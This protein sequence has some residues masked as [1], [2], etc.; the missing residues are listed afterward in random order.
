MIVEIYPRLFLM[1]YITA[2][3]LWPDL[4]VVGCGVIVMEKTWPN[5]FVQQTVTVFPQPDVY[6]V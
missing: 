5:L 4:D 6:L 2:S 3:R 1:V